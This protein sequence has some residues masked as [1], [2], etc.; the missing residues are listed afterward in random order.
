MDMKKLAELV[1]Q[2]EEVVDI[3]IF[4]KNGDP[5]LGLDGEPSTIGVVGTES[6]QY[7]AAEDA[8][9]KRLFSMMR[10]RGGQAI[11]PTVARQEDI[12][13]VLAACVRWSGW[14]DGKKD[15]PFTTEAVR[16]LLQFRHI[17][18]QVKA[19]IDGHADFFTHSSGN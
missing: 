9:R 8:H 3:P 7:M 18:D 11:D 19:G 14:D 5:Y 10:K 16:E 6:K 17:F 2:D 4:Q 15:L 13:V 1:A 12:K